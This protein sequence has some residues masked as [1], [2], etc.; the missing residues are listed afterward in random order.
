M[1][2]H[3]LNG[4]VR[5]DFGAVDG[6]QANAAA[7][8]GPLHLDWLFLAAAAAVLHQRPQ[9]AGERPLTLAMAE[10]RARRSPAT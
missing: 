4:K 6:K 5:I 7:V 1:L 2:D 10:L 8:R 3:A 9:H